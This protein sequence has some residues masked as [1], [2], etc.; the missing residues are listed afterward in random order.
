L[1]TIRFLGAKVLI[2]ATGE[3]LDKAAPTF[4]VLDAKVATVKADLATYEG[5]ET[6]YP[7]NQSAGKLVEAIAINAGV[8]DSIASRSNPWSIALLVTQML[9]GIPQFDSKIYIAA[10]I[11]AKLHTQLKR[12]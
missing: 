10:K 9:Y 8:G 7:Q 12:E 3:S 4:E 5:V 2:N 1:R 6:L 11:R